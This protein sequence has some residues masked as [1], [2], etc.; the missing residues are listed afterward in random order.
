MKDQAAARPATPL[1]HP[2]TCRVEVLLWDQAGGSSKLEDHS[3]QPHWMGE[4]AGAG[5]WARSEPPRVQA[6]PE[7]GPAHP[8]RP[9][10]GS[11]SCFSV[12]SF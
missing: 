8:C 10:P 7:S 12:Q 4:G 5:F 2:H 9:P 11:L 1:P 3:V 6:G